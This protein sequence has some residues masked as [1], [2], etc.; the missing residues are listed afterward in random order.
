VA[1]PFDNMT[2]RRADTVCKLLQR[3]KPPSLAAANRASERARIP[4][5]VRI[6]MWAQALTATQPQGTLDVGSTF[7]QRYGGE[8]VHHRTIDH[9]KS[10]SVGGI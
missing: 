10:A 1:D 5:R 2:R 9:A 6:C 8:T 4:I 3:P 7:R